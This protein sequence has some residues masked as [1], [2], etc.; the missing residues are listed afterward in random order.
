MKI[1]LVAP[2]VSDDPPTKTTYQ[3]AENLYRRLAGRG[4]ECVRFMKE[5]CLREKL[6]VALQKDMGS[7]GILVYLDHG[8][9]CTLFGSDDKP[10]IDL[11][12]IKLLKNKFVFALACDSAN[13][14]GKIGV[15]E[16]GV[17]GYL[18][19]RDEIIIPK[20]ISGLEEYIEDY[21]R[22]L[23]SGL[24]AMLVKKVDSG[25]CRKIIKRDITNK[26]SEYAKRSRYPN[27]EHP[28]SRGLSDALT[29]I[30]LIGDRDWKYQRNGW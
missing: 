8:C 12:N 23:L 14:L 28:F 16:Y 3:W 20:K 29:C 1:F 17:K 9:C 26:L 18:G 25:Q 11:K 27:K 30:D 5:G 6:E 10:I 21:E 4:I 19:F 2:L 15:A 24:M 22:C 7:P 13:F